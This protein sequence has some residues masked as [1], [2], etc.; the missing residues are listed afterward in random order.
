MILALAELS[1][2]LPNPD[3]VVPEES[4]LGVGSCDDK[5]TGSNVNAKFYCSGVRYPKC[6]VS[7]NPPCH[8][9]K[10]CSTTCDYDPKSRKIKGDCRSRVF[11]GF[12]MEGFTIDA[13]MLNANLKKANLRD[14]SINAQDSDAFSFADLEGADLT[15]AKAKTKE[16]A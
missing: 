5:C 7:D 15:G 2:C 3:S 10:I 4:L 9:G 13:S 12:N 8:P 11:E 16:G 14:T 6:P 1:F